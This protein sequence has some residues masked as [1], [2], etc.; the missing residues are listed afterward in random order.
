MIEF[1]FYSIASSKETIIK[2]LEEATRKLKQSL[3]T[4]KRDEQFVTK[5]YGKFGFSFKK[6]IWG[7]KQLFKELWEK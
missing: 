4:D 7:K 3:S 5:E 1:K 2:Q 6:I